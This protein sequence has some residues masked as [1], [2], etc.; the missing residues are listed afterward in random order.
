MACPHTPETS[1]RKRAWHQP[2][3]ILRIISIL[4]TQAVVT[5]VQALYRGYSVRISLKAQ[6]STPAK[7]TL[8]KGGAG[9]GAIGESLR[10]IERSGTGSGSTSSASVSTG[11]L[12]L[13]IP[14][15]RRS[16]LTKDKAA[17]AARARRDCA[18]RRR[19]EREAAIAEMKR[20]EEEGDRHERV[21]D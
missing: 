4:Q 6:P 17:A 13:P 21:L 3:G 12:A 11:A 5:R 16:R 7:P 14:L 1:W 20:L 19:W 18:F 9:A 8:N 2:S 10:A 15:P